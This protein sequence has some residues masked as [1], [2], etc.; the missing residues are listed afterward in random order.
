VEFNKEIFTSTISIPAS[1]QVIFVADLFDDDYV[2][3]AELTTKALI[4]SSPYEV[5]KLHSKDVNLG[6]LKQGHDKFWIFGN[7]AQLN[8]QLIPSI[9]ANIKYSIVEYDYK[10]CKFRSPEKHHNITKLPCD[11]HNQINGKL[12]SAFFY[13]AKHLWWMSEKQKEKYHTLFPFLSEKDNTVLSS[14]FDDRTLSYIKTLQSMEKEER[15]KWIVLGSSSWIKGFEAAKNWCVDNNKEYKVVWNMSYDELLAELAV[16]KGFVYL[17]EGCDTCPRMVIEAKLLGCEL[18]TNEYVQ[19]RDESW[20]ATDDLNAI[21]EYLYAAPKWF[22]NGIKH[23]MEYKPTIS[24]YITTYNCV[25][26]RYPFEQ[27]IESMLSFCDEVCVLDG[28]STDGTWENLCQLQR[29][30]VSSTVRIRLYDCEASR[31]ESYNKESPLKLKQIT[32]DWNHPRFAVFDGEQK[33]EAR[34]M[35]T[36]EFCW[37]MDSDEIVHEVDV[38]K[39][40]NILNAITKDI[41]VLSLPVVE[42]WGGPD[43]VR[44]D[45]TPWKWRLSRNK[46]YIT[47]GIPKDLR[48]TDSNGDLF[49]SEGTDG[50][51]LIHAETFERIPH[52]SFYTPE[53]E[54]IRQHAML[55]N[56]QALSDYQAWF[57]EVV[58]GLPCVYHYSW[59]DLERKIH[60]YKNY[61]TKHWESLTG[62]TYVDDAKSNMMFDLPWSEVTNEMIKEKAKELQ[63]TGGHIWHRKWNGTITPWLTIQHSEPKVMQ[64]FAKR[65][66]PS[67]LDIAEN[68]V[69]HQPTDTSLKEFLV[70]AVTRKL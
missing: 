22:W 21:T 13:G 38:P 58:N 6:T 8:P 70:K 52:A 57:Q 47:H 68:P 16:S 34:R 1:S 55:G 42:Y 9:I 19:H 37:Q 41:D 63:K 31:L 56:K 24:G 17:P 39:I 23:A 25:K 60:L 4:E 26:Q 27:S 18:H 45:V 20:F 59:Y 48:K 14:V 66:S 50:C 65:I 5:F 30:L 61:W 40:K 15:T 49:A 43:K 35:C 51:D 69:I 67:L 62:K 64:N 28:G 46:P 7:F 10:Y 29:N 11:C 32:R 54:N 36:S 12:I 2:G 3:G 33:A 44:L 53:V